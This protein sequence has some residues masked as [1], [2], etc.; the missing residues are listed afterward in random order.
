MLLNIG[1]YRF[2]RHEREVYYLVLCDSVQ[3]ESY[4]RG[5]TFLTLDESLDMNG[6]NIYLFKTDFPRRRLKDFG[7]EQL[8]FSFE[9]L[10][11]VNYSG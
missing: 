3:S 7:R 4:L 10:S 1:L 2:L 11:L 8:W 6:V 9:E 5:F